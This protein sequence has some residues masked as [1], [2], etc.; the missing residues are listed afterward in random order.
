M[1]T[2]SFLVKDLLVDWRIG[3]RWFRTLLVDGDVAQ[4]AGNWQWVAGTGPDA[5]PYFRIFNPT[6]QARKFDPDGRYVRRFVPE[7]ASLPDR[8]IHDP[9]A[10]PPAVLADAGITLGSTYPRPIIDHS[11]ARSRVL[12]AYGA[13]RSNGRG[14]TLVRTRQ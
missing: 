10:A 1:I 12:G 8:W 4:N 3:E 9:S 11:F 6:L 7:L 13:A 14:G 2:A 5:A